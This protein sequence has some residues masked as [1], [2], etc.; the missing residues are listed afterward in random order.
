MP[1]GRFVLSPEVEELLGPKGVRQLAE[2]ER[3]TCVCGVRARTD[4]EPVSVYVETD[5]VEDGTPMFRVGFAHARCRPSRVV[6]RPG[7]VEEMLAAADGGRRPT[8]GFAS[9]GHGRY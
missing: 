8:S 7:L 1:R 9:G 3:S 4:A 2:V 6:H 5:Q